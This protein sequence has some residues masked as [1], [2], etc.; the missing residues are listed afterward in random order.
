MQMRK[1]RS[2]VFGKLRGD[3]CQL[4]WVGLVVGEA[5]FPDG[6]LGEEMS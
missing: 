4:F 2:F 5:E 6:A 1:G 3:G